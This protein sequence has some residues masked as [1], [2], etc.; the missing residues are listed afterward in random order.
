MNVS[1]DDNSNV[2]QGVNVFMNTNGFS[3]PIS[4]CLNTPFIVRDTLVNVD[5]VNTEKNTVKNI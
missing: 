1:F 5:I 2:R 3:A 4:L